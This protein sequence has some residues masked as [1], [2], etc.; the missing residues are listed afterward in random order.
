MSV[1]F[2]NILLNLLLIQNF[3][4]FKIF[5]CKHIP[6]YDYED[7]SQCINCVGNCRIGYV[8]CKLTYRLIVCPFPARQL[9]VALAHSLSLLCRLVRELFS[10]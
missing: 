3:K 10:G 7:M 9:A 8:K 4:Y 2:K 5:G 6:T 1:G